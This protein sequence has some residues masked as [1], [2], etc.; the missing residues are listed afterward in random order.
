MNLNLSTIA[1]FFWSV[2][3]VMMSSFLNILQLM[4]MF[5][6]LH[7]IGS[8]AHN[9][10]DRHLQSPPSRLL[11]NPGRH[12]RFPTLPRKISRTEHEEN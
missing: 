4:L 9:W 2:I 10:V 7:L 1:F 3:V 12:G 11:L 6:Q 8:Q 5:V